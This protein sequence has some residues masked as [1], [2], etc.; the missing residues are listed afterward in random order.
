MT[1]E[2]IE[3]SPLARRLVLGAT[4]PVQENSKPELQEESKER[5]DVKSPKRQS[6]TRRMTV[7]MPEDLATRLEIYAVKHRRQIKG[8]VSGVITLQ[9]KKLLAEEE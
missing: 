4:P 2:K 3:G 1:K 9:I 5:Q 8:G 7:Y 6:T